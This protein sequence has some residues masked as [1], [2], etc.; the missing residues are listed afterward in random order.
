[1]IT[2]DRCKG[3]ITGEPYQDAIEW[4]KHYHEDCFTIRSYE[5]VCGSVGHLYETLHKVQGTKYWGKSLSVV[6]DDVPE[7]FARCKF[8][9][10]TLEEILKVLKLKGKM[11][12]LFEARSKDEYLKCL[13][14]YIRIEIKKD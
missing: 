1:M 4:N 8:Y 12:E 11:S 14:E 6:L 10:R 3:Q 7:T 2:C 13:V 9:E 5:L